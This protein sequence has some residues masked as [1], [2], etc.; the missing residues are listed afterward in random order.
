VAAGD[1]SAASEQPLPLRLGLIVARLTLG[2]RGGEMGLFEDARAV[3]CPLW[4]G[5]R[6]A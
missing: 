2:R 3:R 6:C 5:E 4:R 1:L